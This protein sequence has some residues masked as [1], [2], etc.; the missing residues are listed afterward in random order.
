MH[1][2]MTSRVPVSPMALLMRDV[3]DIP[4]PVLA[5]AALRSLRALASHEAALS[6]ALGS[7]LHRLFTSLGGCAPLGHSRRE[8]F[9]RARLGISWSA[10][11]ELR[12][13]ARGLD[14]LPVLRSAYLSGDLSP[15]KLRLVLRVATPETEVGWLILAKRH[16]TR[17]IEKRVKAFRQGHD[18][19]GAAADELEAACAS[20]SDSGSGVRVGW[21]ATDLDIAL[22]RGWGREMVRTFVGHRVS[23]ADIAEAIAAEALTALDV[24]G[25]PG[26]CVSVVV[27]SRSAP[28]DGDVTAPGV[29][30]LT[31]RPLPRR[32]VRG[33]APPLSLPD[34]AAPGT[35]WKMC[36]LL[37]DLMA[38][39]HGLEAERA[40]LLGLVSG[41]SLHHELGFRKFDDFLQ[42]ALGMAPRDAAELLHLDNELSLMLGV[43]DAWMGGCVSKLQASLIARVADATTED[44]WLREVGCVSVKRLEL[45]VAWHE[46]VLAGLGRDAYLTLTQGLPTGLPTSTFHLDWREMFGV[47][48]R[49]RD[50]ERERD[51][52]E[53]PPPTDAPAPS[54]SPSTDD[55]AP[56]APAPL[57]RLSFRCPATV[58]DLL[59]R[60]VG[61]VSA[62]LVS[63]GAPDAGV[64]ASIRWMLVHFAS[65]HASPERE[66]EWTSHAIPERDR[67]TCTMP[68][69]TE[70]RVLQVH[71]IHQRARG[72]PLVDWNETTLCEGCH[73]GVIQENHATM[74]GRAPDDVT[75]IFG[76][77]REV[78]RDERLVERAARL[79]K[80]WVARREPAFPAA[81]AA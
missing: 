46:S 77:R 43:R 76:D 64:A 67:W 51:R 20:D 11:K 15:A 57:R 4:R 9:A 55:V 68:H 34:V 32:A 71:H 70:T 24:P 44:A 66:R 29:E 35:A 42:R 22:F 21:L 16:G 69:C 75:I 79:K 27:A 39:R 14:S 48:D 53:A 72:G 38:E 47:R 54:P 81:D 8:D 28:D 25:A 58:A 12:S 18:P 61:C 40:C 17:Q 41:R 80:R 37:G 33:A 56:S 45:E 10:C 7:A 23:D 26:G 30:D 52:S 65:V 36:E 13:I 2:P 60:A 62:H 31:S 74:T 59:A 63:I 5:A 6:L 73:L 1:A 19:A 78:W 50:R 49:D 3:D